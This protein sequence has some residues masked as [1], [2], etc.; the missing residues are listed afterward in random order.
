MRYITAPALLAAAF[1][2][3]AC[4]D[5]PTAALQSGGLQPGGPNFAHTANNQANL[6]GM[7]N[8]NGITGNAIT[9]YVAGRDGWQST[10]NL[11][12]DL[13]A[14]T[15][16]FFAIGPGGVQPVCSFTV[17]GRGG[18]QGC[19]ADTDL[20]GFA[21]AEVQYQDGTVVASGIFE[22]RGGNREK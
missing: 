9:N 13:A 4:A 2:A 10:V 21:R 1:L 5:A 19:S 7:Q 11:Q 16:T 22:R 17:G 18:R 3:A 6:S 14:G 15:Y 12:G 8:G 20:G